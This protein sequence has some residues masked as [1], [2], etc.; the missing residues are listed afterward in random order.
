MSK[1]HHFAKVYDKCSRMDN[2][3]TFVK[4]L[5]CEREVPLW[6]H[7]AFFW[8]GMSIA[9][10]YYFKDVRDKVDWEET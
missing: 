8:V 1:K 4:Y 5:F 3:K 9:T 6:F 7:L 2:H 10:F